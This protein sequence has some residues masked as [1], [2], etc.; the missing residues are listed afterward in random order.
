MTLLKDDKIAIKKMFLLCLD[1]SSLIHM[2]QKQIVTLS[3][4]GNSDNDRYTMNHLANLFS[5]IVTMFTN[6]LHLK[7]YQSNSF[8]LFNG[9]PSLFS[10]TL[11]ELHINVYL[12][13]DC[14]YLLDGR[15][16]QLRMLFVNVNRIFPLRS[17]FNNKVRYISKKNNI[18]FKRIIV[19]S[20][21][22]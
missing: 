8:I 21:K 18:Y 10:S 6:M 11:M 22:S 5:Y 20:R 16:S 2:F 14:L 15:L 3:V 4:T 19:D 12:F 1:K 17:T 9:Q 7:F 13:D